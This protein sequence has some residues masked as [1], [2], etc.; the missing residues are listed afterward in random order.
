MLISNTAGKSEERIQALL[1]QTSTYATLRAISTLHGFPQS[2]ILSPYTSA[3]PPLL[4][5][6]TARFPDRTL[7]QIEALMADH[8]EEIR[9]LERYIEQG[10]LESRVKEV[11]ELVKRDQGAG[12]V[13]GRGQEDVEGDVEM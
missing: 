7:Q 1:R 3:Q 13:A 11:A 10:G 12:V 5:E 8:E 6:L 4:A 2:Y 9:V